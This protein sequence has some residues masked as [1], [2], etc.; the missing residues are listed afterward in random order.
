MAN[1][2]LWGGGFVALCLV[3]PLITLVTTFNSFNALL[4]FDCEN[5]KAACLK[6]DVWGLITFISLIRDN[7]NIKNM[8]IMNLWYTNKIE[9]CQLVFKLE[10]WA[11]VLHAARF[12]WFSLLKLLENT[13]IYTHFTGSCNSS[14]ECKHVN[15]LFTLQCQSQM[16]DV[17]IRLLDVY[18]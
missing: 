8:T 10:L 12:L 14:N 7:M 17:V 5:L 1:W 15:P 16:I 13:L 11:T 6:D 4:N 18:L 2:R 9:R 3:T